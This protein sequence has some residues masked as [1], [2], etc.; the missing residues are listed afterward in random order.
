MATPTPLK[1][2]VGGLC[3]PIAAHELLLL[4]GNV[5]GISGFIHRAVKGSVEGLAGAIGLAFSGLLISNLETSG[6]AY[7]SLSLPKILLSGLLVGLGTKLANGCTSGHMICGVSRF[8]VRSIAATVTFF[9]AGVITT[10]VVHKDLPVVGQAEWSVG[11]DSYKLLAIQII[12]LSI[13]LILYALTPDSKAKTAEKNSE[14]APP[15]HN[16]LRVFTYLAT[17]FQFGL[18]LRLSNM[19]EAS[20]VLSFLLLPFHP[21]FDPSL[22][23]VAAG[24]LPVGIF[25][26]QF[27]RGGER[28]R[29]GGKWSIPNGGKIDSRLLIGSTI[30]GVGWGMGGICPGPALVNFGRAL[31]SGHGLVPYAAWL[32]SMVLGGLL[33]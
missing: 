18:A 25:L 8:S 3:I 19:T 28:A 10:Q 32:G 30:F 14:E 6:P 24:A 5:F 7:L 31:G 20:R 15:S 23:L 4:N 26:Y 2:L 17:A 16:A 13:S 12:P 29:L 1:A 9:T 21:G 33:V 22:A 27:A 11:A